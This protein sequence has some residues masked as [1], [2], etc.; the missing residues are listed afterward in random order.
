MWTT[1]TPLAAHEVYV[2]DEASR[3]DVELLNTSMTLSLRDSSPLESDAPIFWIDGEFVRVGRIAALG[4]K[5]YRLSRF[6]RGCYASFGQAPPHLAGAQ[7]LL[8]DAGAALLLSE[9]NV[10]LGQ[11]VLVEAQGVGDATPVSTATKVEGRAIKPLPPV[12]GRAYRNVDGSI[13]L[14]WKRRSRRDLGWVDGVDQAQIEDEESYRVALTANEIVLR[15]WVVTANALRITA[16]EVA[17]AGIPA[18]ALPIFH[19]RQVGRFAQSDT[20]IFSV[21]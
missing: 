18:N 9:P 1:L 19:I 5:T 10:V 4:G 21:S 15:E 3:I 20:L 6:S 7:I 13:D 14:E 17:A 8:M 11:V 16:S 12:H 2:L